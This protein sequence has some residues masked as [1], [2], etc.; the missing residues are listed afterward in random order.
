MIIDS[1]QRDEDG[2]VHSAALGDKD[3]PFLMLIQI[4]PTCWE[5]ERPFLLLLNVTAEPSNPLPPDRLRG[6]SSSSRNPSV[7]GGLSFFR[8]GGQRPLC[9]SLLASA[10]RE[11]FKRKT[12]RFGSEFF[13]IESL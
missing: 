4:C 2:S 12:V 1:R 8:A 5:L 3:S 6:G 9:L 10:H 13:F 11:R 7:E